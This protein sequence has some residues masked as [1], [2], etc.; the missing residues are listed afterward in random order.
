MEDAKD[1]KTASSAA[2]DR[3][4]DDQAQTRDDEATSSETL[5]SLEES[6]KVTTVGSATVSA[7]GGGSLEGASPTPTNEGDGGGRADGGDT[8]GPM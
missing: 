7:S 2:T 1:P 5:S 6:A 3:D 8:G 4:A